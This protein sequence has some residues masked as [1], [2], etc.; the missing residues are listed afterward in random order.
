MAT[1]PP[2][3][4]M[5]QEIVPQGAAVSSGVVMGLAWATGAVG[6]LGTGLL[7]DAIGPQLATLLSMPVILVA[8]GLALHPALKSVSASGA[9]TA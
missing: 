1:L 9:E 7:A 6:V 3:V 2:I 8:V 4:V 5:A